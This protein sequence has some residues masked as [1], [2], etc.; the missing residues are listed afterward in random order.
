MWNA[1]KTRDLCDHVIVI[2]VPQCTRQLLVVHG[3]FVL[4]LTPHLR[5][6]LSTVQ[7]ELAVVCHPLYDLAVLSVCQQFQQKLPQLD[8]TIV[9]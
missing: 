4:A 3:R 6:G 9:A 1:E 7:L 5:N 8:L 2:V